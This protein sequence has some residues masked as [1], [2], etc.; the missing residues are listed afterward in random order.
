MSRPKPT[1]AWFSAPE[2]FFSDSWAMNSFSSIETR[3]NFS[4]TV[5]LSS[6]IEIDLSIIQTTV[7]LW[8]RRCRMISRASWSIATPISLTSQTGSPAILPPPGLDSGWLTA[9]MPGGDFGTAFRTN[10]TPL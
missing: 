1:I 10:S 4:M 5:F 6:S 9:G 3:S 8:S 2:F 7:T